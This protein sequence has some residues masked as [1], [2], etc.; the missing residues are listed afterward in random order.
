[1]GSEESDLTRGGVQLVQALERTALTVGDPVI[2][3]VA[4]RDGLVPRANS[5]HELAGYDPVTKDG[6][7]RVFRNARPPEILPVA[8]LE[9][10]QQLH[11]RVV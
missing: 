1:M 8:V 2:G 11:G 7:R 6:I 9:F 3:E 4:E 10:A 5:R